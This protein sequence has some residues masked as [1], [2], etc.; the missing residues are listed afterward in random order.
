MIITS[1][2]NSYNDVR[3]VLCKA[4]CKIRLSSLK[5][6]E[7]DQPHRV[8]V[9]RPQVPPPTTKTSTSASR[10]SCRETM[11]ISRGWDNGDSLRKRSQAW[12]FMSH[13]CRD[14]V[15]TRIRGL[16]TLRSAIYIWRRLRTSLV[17]ERTREHPRKHLTYLTAK[18]QPG[19]LGLSEGRRTRPSKV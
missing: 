11:G 18:P 19:H 4:L 15:K 13:A 1:F 8:A 17:A 2:N 14:D 12:R 9:A 3:T 16:M 6:M 5:G 7:R 10:R